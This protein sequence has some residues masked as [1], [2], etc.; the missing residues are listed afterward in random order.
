MNILK[1]LECVADFP[2]DQLED[3][4]R[5][6]RPGGRAVAHAICDLLK[7]AGWIT[8]NP[9]LDHEHGWEFDAARE[10]ALY[11]MLVTDL[12]DHKILIQTEDHSRSWRRW[13]G[14]NKERHAMFRGELYGLLS[15]DE[16][17]D[18]VNWC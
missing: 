3:G 11:W 16:R 12:G 2:D 8:T 7:D 18:S 15:K 14:T 17:F 4:G 1:T 13:L 6:V 10:G 5:I 9:E